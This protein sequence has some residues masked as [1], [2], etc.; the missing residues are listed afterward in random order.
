MISSIKP[1]LSVV[2]PVFNELENIKELFCK[3]EEFA[4]K[5]NFSYK[6]IL[7]DGC[8]SDNTPDLI[9]K[10]ILNYPLVN[11]E[12]IR[13]DSRNGYGFD[14]MTGL[15]HS[16]FQTLAWTH[17]DLQTDLLDLLKGY[18]LLHESPSSSVVKGKRVNRALLEKLFTFG[19]QIYTF[20]SLKIYLD[21]INAQPK[22]FH[23]D[24]YKKYL[25]DNPP[26]DFSLDLFF[27]IQARKNQF[28]IKNFNVAFNPRHAGVAKGGGGSWKNRLLLVRR[29]INYIQNLRL[30]IS[31]RKKN[32]FI[33]FLIFFILA[34]KISVI[35]KYDV[36][37]F[38]Y[39]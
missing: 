23:F 16:Q 32:Y 26:D 9:E 1:G 10:Q 12:L 25:L 21:D 19:M 13:M 28:K 6:F 17:A 33:G 18:Q 24:F 34:Y 7:V 37:E 38:Y 39:L 2:I 36:V 27:L 31:V 22:I 3:F 15:Q 29:T 35:N 5:A 20:L 8:S 14:I 11:V 30:R 4:L